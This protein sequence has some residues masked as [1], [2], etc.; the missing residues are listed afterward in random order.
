MSVNTY[1]VQTGKFGAMILTCMPPSVTDDDMQGWIQNPSELRKALARMLRPV[2][3]IQGSLPGLKTWR[4]M[5]IGIGDMQ[6]SADFYRALNQA[7]HISKTHLAL[8][9]GFDFVAVPHETEIKLV[10]VSLGDIG[11]P[12]GATRFNIYRRA[13]QLGLKLCPP[14][15]APRLCL[16][17][18]SSEIECIHVGMEPIRET[19]GKELVIFGVYYHINAPREVNLLQGSPY[20]YFQNDGTWIFAR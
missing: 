14:E 6:S 12:Y 7:G 3:S 19:D 4:T 16:E 18:E 8:Y 11:F 17:R 2:D 10:Q 13:D 5:K 20:Y 9:E 15:L 1:D